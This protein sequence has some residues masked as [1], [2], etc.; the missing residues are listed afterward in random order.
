[1]VLIG[2]PMETR[3][4]LTVLREAVIE[5]Q[6]EDALQYVFDFQ[7]A[8]VYVVDIRG[9]YQIQGGVMPTEPPIGYDGP[10][11]AVPT[12]VPSVGTCVVIVDAVSSVSRAK[13]CR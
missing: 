8:P 12:P 13:T 7:L 6:G 1:M 4:E 10:V 3:A 11:V 2:D 9:T 5:T